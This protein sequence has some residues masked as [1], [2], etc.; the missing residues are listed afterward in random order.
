[1]AKFI[2]SETFLRWLIANGII[3]SRARGVTIRARVGEL[4]TIE[5]EM[6]GDENLMSEDAKEVFASARDYVAQPHLDNS[7]TNPLP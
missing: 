3:A 6:F 5:V 4:V 2:Q 7:S 1:M